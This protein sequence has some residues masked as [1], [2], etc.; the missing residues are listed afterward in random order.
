MSRGRMVTLLLGLAAPVAFAAALPQEKGGRPGDGKRPAATPRKDGEAAQEGGFLPNAFPP[1][2]SD[3]KWHADAW[4]RNDCLRCHE[5]GVSDAPVV[6]HRG[7][8][9]LLK[10][11]KCRSC[12]VLE[13]GKRPRPPDERAERAD[14]FLPNAFPPMIPASPSHRNAWKRD[15]CRLCHENG[16]SGAPKIVHRGM[17]EIL[18]VSKCRSCHVQV[19]AV[20]AEQPPALGPRGG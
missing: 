2:L 18:K 3:T 4:L 17:P 6:R 14:G 11:A 5:T 20:E 12:H 8:P 7:M 10:A 16:I 15:D 19:R 1:T 9:E 13:P